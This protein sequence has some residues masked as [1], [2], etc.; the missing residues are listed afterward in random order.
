MTTF[1]T[2]EE[3]AGEALVHSPDAEKDTCSKEYNPRN[4]I[5]LRFASLRSAL[6]TLPRVIKLLR[7]NFLKKIKE[8]YESSK[9]T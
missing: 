5:E 6:I 2:Q 1:D 3:R 7:V 9:N 4:V 8:R